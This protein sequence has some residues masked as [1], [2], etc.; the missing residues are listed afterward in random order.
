MEDKDI[1]QMNTEDLENVAGGIYPP[2]GGAEM[3]KNTSPIDAVSGI[4]GE[5]K[6]VRGTEPRHEMRKAQNPGLGL[7]L[8]NE[9]NS[10]LGLGI[11]Q[12]LGQDLNSQ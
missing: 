1:R 8:N 9:L 12:N 5:G 11:G 2:I 3:I 10:E 4:P 7:G 6:K